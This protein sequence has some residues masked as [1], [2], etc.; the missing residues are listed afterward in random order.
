[1]KKRKEIFLLFLN[2]NLFLK[3]KKNII[4]CFVLNKDI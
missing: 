3:K 4:K 1:M 2:Y